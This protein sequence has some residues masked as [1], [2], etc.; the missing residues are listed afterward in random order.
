MKS[1]LDFEDYELIE[2]NIRECLNQLLNKGINA[3]FIARSLANGSSIYFADN[4]NIKYRFS[5]HSVTNVGRIFN[6]I[7]FK[8]PYRITGSIANQ[9]NCKD[10]SKFGFRERF[11]LYNDNINN[12]AKSYSYIF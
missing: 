10:K 7:H 11:V 8:L 2:L 3:K 9:F 6:E 12:L 5:D 1:I 4:N